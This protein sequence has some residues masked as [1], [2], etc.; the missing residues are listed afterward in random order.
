MDYWDSVV[1]LIVFDIF[2]LDFEKKEKKNSRYCS[3]YLTWYI[4]S[5]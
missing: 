2:E 5:F 3:I 4:Q 1:K